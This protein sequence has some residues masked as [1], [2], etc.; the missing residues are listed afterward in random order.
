MAADIARPSRRRPFHIGTSRRAAVL[1]IACTIATLLPGT[2]VLARPAGEAPIGGG[3]SPAG[4]MPP[5]VPVAGNHDTLRLAV[6]ANFRAPLND[7]AVVFE[8]RHGMPLSLTFGSSGLLAAQIRQG[9]PFDAF[10]SADTKRPQTLID[11]GLAAAPLTVYARGRVALRSPG[12]ATAASRVG[13]RRVGIPNPQLAPYGAAAMQ[14]LERLGVTGR[15]RNRLVFGNNVNQVDHF[16]ES[17]ALDAGFVA[18]SQ[19]V[20][21][22]VPA[23]RYWVCPASFHVPIDQG[24][25]VLRRS[26]HPSAARQLLR[27]MTRPDTQARLAQLGYPPGD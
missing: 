21:R 7:L 11:D 4:A 24:A 6:A 16:L 13:V 23:E 18:L 26:R 15:F 1:A 10:F 9:A 27:F 8:R 17:G 14:C 20:A 2:A 19:L 22:A 12:P 25:V 3:A 5:V